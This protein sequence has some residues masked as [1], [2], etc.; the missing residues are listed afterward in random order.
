MAQSTRCRKR[1]RFLLVL[2]V[3]LAFLAG[4]AGCTRRFFR[5]RA[6]EQVDA[7]MAEKDKYPSWQ[8]DQYHVYPDPRARFAD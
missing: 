1:G 5:K 3:G 4:G 8:I 7:L 6:D 2:L